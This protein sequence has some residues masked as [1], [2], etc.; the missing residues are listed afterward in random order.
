MVHIFTQF[1]KYLF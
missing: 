1:H